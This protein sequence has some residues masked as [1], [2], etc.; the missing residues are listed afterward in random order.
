[1]PPPDPAPARSFG[2]FLCHHAPGPP[3]EDID[4]LPLPDVKQDA[5]LRA[6][7]A[8]RRRGLPIGPDPAVAFDAEPALARLAYRN[9]HRDALR[10]HLGRG[11]DRTRNAA[12]WQCRLSLDHGL[13]ALADP[14]QQDALDAVVA[15]VTATARLALLWHEGTLGLPP[16]TLRRLLR[17]LRRVQRL[18]DDG[19]TVVPATSGCDCG[20]SAAPPACRS[21]PTPLFS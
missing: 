17:P 15:Q 6:L 2:A 14:R 18:K 11:R 13:D 10:H 7:V 1:V 20:A 9:A 4:R 12:R 5:C 8:L 16:A 21:P 3:F 19:T